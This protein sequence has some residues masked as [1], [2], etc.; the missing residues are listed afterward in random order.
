MGQFR[1]YIFDISDFDDNNLTV[2]QSNASNAP[3][4]Q[5]ILHYPQQ[6]L[7]VTIQNLLKGRAATNLSLLMVSDRPRFCDRT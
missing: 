5:I 3:H 2:G 6:N 7:V 4:E 1:Q